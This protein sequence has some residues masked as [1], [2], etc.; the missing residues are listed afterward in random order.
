MAQEVVELS[1]LMVMILSSFFAVEAR[2]LT[3][4]VFGLFTATASLG[5]IFLLLGAFQVGLLQLLIYAGGLI[6]LFVMVVLLTTG[7]D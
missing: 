4:A 1:L 2:R 3:R 7:E 5:G 6:A